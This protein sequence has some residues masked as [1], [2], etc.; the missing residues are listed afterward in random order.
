MLPAAIYVKASAHQPP[1]PPQA[2]LLV[3][4]LLHDLLQYGKHPTLPEAVA[5]IHELVGAPV[6]APLHP[7]LSLHSPVQQGVEVQGLRAA[8][9]AQGSQAAV[10][11]A[12]VGLVAGLT[13]NATLI[14]LSGVVGDWE[15]GTA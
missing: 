5:A 11:V 2:H 7:A 14:G 15:E 3:Q 6:E 9:Q 10:G 4:L 1:N 12:T 13:T 8:C